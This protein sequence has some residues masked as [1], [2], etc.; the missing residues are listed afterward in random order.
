MN[1]KKSILWTALSTIAGLLLGACEFGDGM[2]SPAGRDASQALA[3]STAPAGWKIVKDRIA[4]NTFTYNAGIKVG[5]NQTLEVWA[6]AKEAGTDPILMAYGMGQYASNANTAY[7]AAANND[8]NG[9][10]PYIKWKNA[11]GSEQ[12][13]GVLCFANLPEPSGAAVAPGHASVL[14]KLDGNTVS[15]V[16][17][18]VV[19]GKLFQENTVTTGLPPCAPTY[20]RI[21]YYGLDHFNEAHIVAFNASNFLGTAFTYGGTMPTM[22]PTRLYGPRGDVLIPNHKPNGVLVYRTVYWY[23][24]TDSYPAAHV[25]FIQE[26]YFPCPG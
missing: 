17:D 2:S 8:F 24:P 19:G 21:N 12:D 26:D 3:A 18:A 13:M 9:L 20:S 5:P 23:G 4:E 7:F 15:L 10:N 25:H 14:T 11:T 22:D 16:P 1:I 6:T